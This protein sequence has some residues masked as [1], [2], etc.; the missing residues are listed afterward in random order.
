MYNGAKAE[1]ALANFSTTR[2]GEGKSGRFFPTNGPTFLPTKV[3]HVNERLI[4]NEKA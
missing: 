3:N 4:K 1:A 2:H